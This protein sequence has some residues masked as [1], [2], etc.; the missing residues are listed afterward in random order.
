[1]GRVR[2]VLAG[3]G[4]AGLVVAGP[5]GGQVQEGPR[6]VA[7]SS[8]FAATSRHADVMAF[9]RELQ[10][11][12]PHVRVEPLATSAEGRVVP[13][14]VVGDPVPASPAD[15]RH[16]DRAVI[17]LQANIH[18]GE[19]EGKEA[20][21]M[22]V[23]DILQGRAPNYLD[24][25]VLLVVPIFNADGNERISTE[26]RTNQKGPVQGVGTR[27]NGQNLDLNRDGMKVESPEVAG[28]V[29][30][31]NRWDP[32]FFLD[33]HTHNG[34]YHQEPV[35]W[36]WGL[37][38][39]GDAGVIDYMANTM[40]PAVERSMREQFKTAVIPHGDFVDPRDPAK[41]W[42]PL[43]PQPRYLS[44][45]VGLRNRLSVL[46]EQYPY[47]DFETRV[48]GCYHLL[49]AFL[50]FAHA[51]RDA[52]V[53]VVREADRRTIARA[54]APSP[55]DA[56]IVES[57][58]EPVQQR[59]TIQ[60]YEMEISD[61]PGGRPRVRPTD[62]TRT[63]TDVPYLA[64][65]TAKRS[66]RLPRGYLIVSPERDLLQK[67]D[68]HG[69]AVERLTDTATLPVEG[70]RITSIKGSPQLN[71]GHYTNT[72]AGEYFT[73]TKA[74]PAGTAYVSLA[75]RLGPL[76]SALLE[77]ESDDGLLV[78]NAF[79]RALSIQ[80]GGGP[81]DYPVYRLHGAGSFVRE[82]VRHE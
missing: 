10:R 66:V 74:F 49:R 48:R 24:R 77:A 55:T 43:E 35:T 76:A 16:D 12:S 71:Q 36:T 72:V 23:R 80:W 42:V 51:N 39:N 70:F 22:L 3:L 62:R 9:A 78:W 17:Y 21:L 38:P 54:L 25:L 59:F 33:S 44:N 2:I 79:D 19:V 20:T 50:D 30:V 27:A 28:L 14:L 5:V 81:R 75:Q 7:E 18:A 40:W 6:T 67:L 56:F 52:M 11:Q 53:K 34:S 68:L 60:G 82:R 13:M 73:T 47:V 46:N 15:L 31:L 57:N 45:Y 29:D 41:G 37:N 1:M 58:A 61:G 65:Y 32:V 8:G 64:R 26:N 63:Y 4:M 69:I